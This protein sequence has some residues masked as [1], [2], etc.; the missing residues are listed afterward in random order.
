MY[1]KIYRIVYFVRIKFSGI[2]HL[3]NPHCGEYFARRN[4][5]ALKSTHSLDNISINRTWLKTSRQTGSNASGRGVQFRL[6]RTRPSSNVDSSCH[7]HTVRGSSQ[8]LFF[9]MYSPFPKLRILQLYLLRRVI[10]QTY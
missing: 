2:I 1:N 3:R 8:Y 5:R 10:S 9:Y 7:I 4:N 6:E